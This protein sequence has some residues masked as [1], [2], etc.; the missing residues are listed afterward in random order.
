M[1]SEEVGCASLLCE[2]PPSHREE[3]HSRDKSFSQT[4]HPASLLQS[5]HTKHNPRLLLAPL[6]SSG[7][8]LTGICQWVQG[9][10]SAEYIL[11][12]RGNKT[13]PNQISKGK[14]ALPKAR[15]TADFQP[16]DKAGHVPLPDASCYSDKAAGPCPR[17]AQMALG[18]MEKPGCPG[19]LDSAGDASVRRAPCKACSEPGF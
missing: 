8:S 4:Q 18:T 7:R 10:P 9:P 5:Q 19:S 1:A 2:S 3:G 14:A 17:A 13:H 15:Q 12:T 16:T 11:S 6:L